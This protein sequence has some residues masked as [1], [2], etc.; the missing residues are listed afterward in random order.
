MIIV[1]FALATFQS[2][3]L[4][5]WSKYLKDRC[6]RFV[7]NATIDDSDQE[8]F[9]QSKINWTT[10]N[11]VERDGERWHINYK[12]EAKQ[13]K[14]TFGREVSAVDDQVLSCY[15]LFGV[16]GEVKKLTLKGEIDRN[17]SDDNMIGTALWDVIYA[18]GL[19]KS[20]SL[21]SV[22]DLMLQASDLRYVESGSQIKVSASHQEDR[23]L[24]VFEKSRPCPIR[25][26]CSYPVFDHEKLTGKCE[27]VV[28]EIVWDDN[29]S[30]PISLMA[31]EKTSSAGRVNFRSAHVKI[32]ELPPVSLSRSK[33]KLDL[34]TPNGK[35]VSSTRAHFDCV[36]DNSRI[37]PVT[38]RSE[39][40]AFFGSRSRVLVGVL[41]L[42]SLIGG[43]FLLRKPVGK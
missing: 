21:A 22:P 39:K 16:S 31:T 28:S 2:S 5:G 13:E 20:S 43:Y 11:L 24:V 19:Y 38:Q 30:L 23:F 29:F 27:L 1:I 10:R 9:D 35:V 42:I 7:V 32:E 41:A 14:F 25:I 8:T 4:D 26:E 40:L 17:S 18:V 37:V 12:R 3:C 36:L 33:L 6:G 34:E 15:R